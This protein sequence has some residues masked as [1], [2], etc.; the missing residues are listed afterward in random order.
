[1]EELDPKKHEARK[2]QKRP[3]HMVIKYTAAG[4]PYQ[5][6]PYT[7]AEEM[8][9]YRSMSGVVAYTR[10]VKAAPAVSETAWDDPDFHAGAAR[11]YADRRLI[12]PPT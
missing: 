3:D 11:Q 4:S 9:L 6:P 2:R 5:E 10:V 8:E 1:V 7:A 12:K